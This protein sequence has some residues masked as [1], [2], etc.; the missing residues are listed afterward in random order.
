[1]EATTY[2]FEY[3]PSA[4]IVNFYYPARL[5]SKFYT[6]REPIGSIDFSDS[7]HLFQALRSSRALHINMNIS[8]LILNRSRFKLPRRV[9]LVTLSA[10][11]APV[12][13]L[14]DESEGEQQHN[15]TDGTDGVE[16]IGHADRADPWNHG[17]DEDCAQ[18]VSHKGKAN[19]GI[20]NNL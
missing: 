18:H 11:K 10:D 3:C 12:L 1:L 16:N 8:T 9:V 19:K 2:S 5:P 4:I 20:T 7:K 13:A 15:Q 6:C 17:E 14:P